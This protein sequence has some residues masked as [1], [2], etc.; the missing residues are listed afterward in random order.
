[1]NKGNET[2]ASTESVFNDLNISDKDSNTTNIK[3]G[4]CAYCNKLL[5]EELWCKECDPLRMIEGWT[6]GDNNMDM[7]IKDTIYD[8]RNDELTAGFLEYVPFD[9]FKDIR[10]VG[11]GEFTKVYS[12]TWIDGKTKYTKQNDGNWKKEESE[13]IKV[14]LKRLNGSQNMTAKYLNEVCLLCIKFVICDILFFFFL[15]NFNVTNRLK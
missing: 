13:P 12:A 7:F 3:H 9:K 5:T 15:L 10:L 6:S 1:M 2:Q 8:A 11:E 4:N 14:A